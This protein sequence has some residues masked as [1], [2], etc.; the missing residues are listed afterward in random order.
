MHSLCMLVNK[1][2]EEMLCYFK[3]LDFRYIY[4]ENIDSVQTKI[5]TKCKM[6]TPQTTQC[7]LA[8]PSSCFLFVSLYM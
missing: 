8:V 4:I 6:F 7:N 5:Y 1:K 3:T 2:L